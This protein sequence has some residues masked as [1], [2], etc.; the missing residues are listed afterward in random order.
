MG[1]K[2]KRTRKRKP[3]QSIG[4]KKIES[5]L[6]QHNLSYTKEHRIPDCKNIRPLPFDFAIQLST[7]ILIEFQ[8]IQHFKSVRRWKGKKGLTKQQL[9]DAIKV[10]YCKLHDIPLLVISYLDQE[11]IVEILDE[12][13]SQP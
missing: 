9:R 3:R 1:R 12:F 13:L 5:Y 6:I 2:Y 7:L 10:E 4:S 8:G 11:R